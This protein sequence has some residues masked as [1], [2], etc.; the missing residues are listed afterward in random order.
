[1]ESFEYFSKVIAFIALVV[2][3]IAFI[4]LVV[5]VYNTA[6]NKGRDAGTW[7]FLSLFMTPFVA[8]FA[9]HILGE[10]KKKREERIV[11]EE[12]LKIQI[13]EEYDTER[14]KAD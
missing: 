12:L 5:A 7:T 3:I 4:V 8:M 1:M 11:E 9:L 2:F 14:T 6:K 10:T 13:R